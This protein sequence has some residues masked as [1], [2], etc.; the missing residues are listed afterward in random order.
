MKL[1][2]HFKSVN[3]CASLAALLAASVMQSACF[4]P[5]RPVAKVGSGI[6]PETLGA[7]SRTPYLTER[8]PS[9]PT[10][11]WEGRFGRG[12]T[13]VPAV[14]AQL[15]IAS[16]SAKTVTVVDATKGSRYWERRFNGPI[17][18]ALLRLDDRLYG[19]TQSRDGR[20]ESV[21]VARGRHAW[22]FK[23]HSPAVGGA[24]LRDSVIYAGSER[25][26]MFALHIDGGTQLWKIRLPSPIATPPVA[27]GSDLVLITTRDSMLRVDRATGRMQPGV[28]L[29]GSSS[30]PVALDG[31]RMLVPLHP[32]VLHAIA[33]PGM[34]TQWSVVVGAPILAAPAIDTNG[35]AY[36]LTRTADVW[37]IEPSGAA[38]RI[39]AL[40]GA[41]TSSL[42]LTAD[43]LL[44]GTLDGVVH[45]MQRDGTILWQRT[46]PRSVRSP[47]AVHGGAI[48]V[49][50][51]DGRLVMLR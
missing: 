4:N 36:V 2:Q 8:V 33:L 40:G 31:D 47:V 15:L 44:V 37:R 20:V 49:P 27:W 23:M 16:S 5:A 14:D 35:D 9:N 18:G 19:A 38:R 1:D 17:A 48:Y 50:L 45:M 24:L 43:G 42:T 12:Y 7:A 28:H 25:G 6:W 34:T 22:T 29:P 10:I 51:G 3:L 46:F 30:A 41:A 13:D 11:Q 26:D 21:S 32:G 39:A